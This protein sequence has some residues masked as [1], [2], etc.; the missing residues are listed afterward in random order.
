M[1][2]IARVNNFKALAVG[3][4]DDHA[5]VLLS[6]RPPIPFP[7][8]TWRAIL[9]RPSG[10]HPGIHQDFRQTRSVVPFA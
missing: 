9:N 3:G 1:G 5:H 2:G 7:P 10:W 4:I 6:L 8:L